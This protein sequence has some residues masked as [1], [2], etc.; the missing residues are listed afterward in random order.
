MSPE[1]QQ[2][3]GEGREG[4]LISLNKNIKIINCYSFYLVTILQFHYAF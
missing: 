2:D 3:S 1:Q 4:G